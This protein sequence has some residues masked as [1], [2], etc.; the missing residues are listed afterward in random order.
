MNGRKYALWV[1]SASLILLPFSPPT[2]MRMTARLGLRT[3]VVVSSETSKAIFVKNGTSTTLIFRSWSQNFVLPVGGWGGGKR[4]IRAPLGRNILIAPDDTRDCACALG[5]SEPVIFA[6][7]VID[8]NR[9]P[10]T[11]WVL[12]V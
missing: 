4:V 7:R 5:V 2:A 6:V 12:A 9:R 3:A 11:C 8:A 10:R 1:C